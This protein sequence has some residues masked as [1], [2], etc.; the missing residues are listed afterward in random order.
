MK[1]GSC[2]E[3]EGITIEHVRGCYAAKQA[4]AAAEATQATDYQPMALA[5]PAQPVP[6]GHYALEVSEGVLEFFRVKAGTKN[7]NIRFVDKL[8]GHPGDWAKVPMHWD[9]QKAALKAI[10]ADHFTDRYSGEDTDGEVIERELS[11]PQASAARFGREFKCCSKCQSPLSDPVS[12]KRA[13][14]PDC[15]AGSGWAA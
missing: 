9:Q 10:Q 5:A 1:C 2:H 12:R 13:M 14:G 15:Y 7:P 4:H 6:E 3:T 8:I 11:G